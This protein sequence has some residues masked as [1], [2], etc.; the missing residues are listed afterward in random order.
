MKHEIDYEHA[1]FTEEFKI[2][3]KFNLNKF[4]QQKSKLRQ[5]NQT[6]GLD[7]SI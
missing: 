3:E 6:E 2:N 4:I 7:D 5:Q 1:R